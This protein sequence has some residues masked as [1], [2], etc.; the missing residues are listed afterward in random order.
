MEQP[1]TLTQR[2]LSKVPDHVATRAHSVRNRAMLLLTHWAGMRVG[3]VA[4]L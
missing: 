3:E 2:E 1:R 4:E